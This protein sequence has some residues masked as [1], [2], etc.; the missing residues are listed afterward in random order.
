MAL[1]QLEATLKKQ[2]WLGQTIILCWTFDSNVGFAIESENFPFAL[3]M[4][5]R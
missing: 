1:D 3:G 5:N 4:R 2:W